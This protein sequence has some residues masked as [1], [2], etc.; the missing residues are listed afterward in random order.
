MFC[1]N[2]GTKVSDDAKFCDNCGSSIGVA[3]LSTKETNKSSSSGSSW[4]CGSIVLIIFVIAYLGYLW[5]SYSS[6]GATDLA[7]EAI[8]EGLEKEGISLRI[9]KISKVRK[10]GE[11]EEAL[12]LFE[13]QIPRNGDLYKGLAELSDGS[14][15]NVCFYRM[16]GDGKMSTN[17]DH[18][19][20]TVLAEFCD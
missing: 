14:T 11:Y 7:K 12:Y 15:A 13:G 10:I 3:Q 1:S 4:G 9:E 8:N 16:I 18:A 20:I 17:P 6:Y 2:C 19:D 5:F